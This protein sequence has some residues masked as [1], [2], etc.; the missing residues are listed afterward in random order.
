MFAVVV[1]MFGFVW[2]VLSCA[3]RC[4]R[5]VVWF[6]VWFVVRFVVWFV[7]CCLVFVVV[8]WLLSFDGRC[9]LFVVGCCLFADV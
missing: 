4:V 8:R 3:V 5:F 6:V 2:Y 9:W 7:V 1:V